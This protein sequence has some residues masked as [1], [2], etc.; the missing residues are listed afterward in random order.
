MQ[1]KNAVVPRKEGCANG[2]TLHPNDAVHTWPAQGQI[3][4]GGEH[5]SARMLLLFWE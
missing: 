4:S 2:A 3:F 5:A 1:L